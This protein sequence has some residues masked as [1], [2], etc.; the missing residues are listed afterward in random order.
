MEEIRRL[1][2]ALEK[3][4]A[5]EPFIKRYEGIRK[6]HPA[7]RPFPRPGDLIAYLHDRRAP[8]Y[9]LNDEI[10]RALIGEFKSRRPSGDV[11]TLCLALLRPG[12]GRIFRIYRRRLQ[13][14][15][16]VDDADL[17]LEIRKEALEVLREWDITK[18][19]MKIPSGIVGRVSNRIRAWY[20]GIEKEERAAVE[21]QREGITIEDEDVSMPDA[22]SPS[23]WIIDAKEILEDLVALRVISETDKFIL[24]GTALYGRS[25]EA[26][27]KELKGLSYSGI[28]QRKSRVTRTL[29]AYLT[30]QAR[31][32]AERRGDSPGE[33][34][35]AEVLRY[36]REKPK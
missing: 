8:S 15:T 31:L 14:V 17:W 9:S 29:K 7:I 32:L 30:H 11:G 1:D 36:L 25:M 18:H 10:F 13:Y 3:E 12:L 23:N 16:G 2:E 35:L 27:S 20:R 21:F 33:V 28:R 24:L 5:S 6:R 34:S 19:P 22:V 4:I 26:L